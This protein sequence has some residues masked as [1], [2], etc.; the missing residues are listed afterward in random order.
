VKAVFKRGIE[1]VGIILIIVMLLLSACGC[2]RPASLEDCGYVITVGVDGGVSKKYYITLMLQRENSGQSS[3]GEGGA[4]LL[5][6][7][8]DDIFEA[9]SEMESNAPY[10]LNFS[11]TGFIVFGYEAAKSGLMKELLDVSLDTLRIRASSIV[12]IAKSEAMELIGG[13]SA[14]DDANVSKLQT[15]VLNDRERTGVV[16]VMSVSRYYEAVHEGRFD[17]CTA[18]AEYNGEI[19]TDM[20]QKKSESEGENPLEKARIGDRIGGLKASVCGTALF[21]GAVFSGELDRLE[22]LYLNMA[23]D[24]FVEATTVRLLPDGSTCTVVLEHKRT[25][26]RAA[27]ILPEGDAAFKITVELYAAAHAEQG[28]A[29]VAETERWLKEDLAAEI[30]Q[31]IACTFKKCVDASCDAFRLGTILSKRFRSTDEWEAYNWKEHYKNSK[32]EF[33]V[34]IHPSDRNSAEGLQ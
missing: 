7:E 29:D 5:A 28:S 10:I 22:T 13:M 24:E 33:E 8:G 6:A 21:N 19:I 18:L 25:K 1:L 34:I 16:A 9:V 31:G 17:F 2:L 3:D 26:I 4:I 30:A 32:V 14:N 11:R 20:G 23:T 15:A 27:D 12:L